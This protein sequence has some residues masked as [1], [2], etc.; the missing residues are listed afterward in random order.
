[1]A[2]EKDP[3]RSVGEKKVCYDYL[4]LDDYQ[5]LN[6]LSSAAGGLEGDSQIEVTRD[7]GGSVSLKFS[8]WGAAFG[9]NGSGSRAQRRQFINRQTIH[10]QMISLFDKTK[11]SVAHVEDD[12]QVSWLKEGYLVRFD[13]F[14]RPLPGSAL[15]VTSQDPEPF[16]PNSGF[17]SRV[18]ATLSW[19][20]P[21]KKERKRRCAMIGADRFVSLAHVV[22]GSGRLGPRFIA[23]QLAAEYVMVAEKEDFAR[24]ATVFGWVAGVSRKEL[25]DLTVETSSGMPEIEIRYRGQPAL[26]EPMLEVDGALQQLTKVG[27]HAVPQSRA[28]GNAEVD[29]PSKKGFHPH[30]PG[31]SPRPSAEHGETS[32]TSETSVSTVAVFQPFEPVELA[33]LIRPICIYR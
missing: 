21:E 11:D 12:G 29:P 25:Y 2:E 26:D 8:L 15:T 22:D 17:W 14:I 32:E 30:W 4:Y 33:A 13:G 16:W 18:R 9:L 27:E 23:L 3:F 7:R 31:R 1:V 6:A 10:S 28:P 20:S 19:S 5:A 24:R